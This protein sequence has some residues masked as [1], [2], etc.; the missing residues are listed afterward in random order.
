MNPYAG[1]R[2]LVTNGLGF[3]GS[4]LSIELVKLGADVTIIDSKVTGCRGYH[5]NI[6]TVAG[7]V[8]VVEADIGD[9]A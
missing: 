1:R 7:K 8:Q 3:L 4:N 2:V 9:S 5:R 6:A